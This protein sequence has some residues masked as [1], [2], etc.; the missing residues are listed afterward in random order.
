MLGKTLYSTLPSVYRKDTFADEEIFQRLYSVLGDK[1]GDAYR[2]VA[3][4]LVD[5]S[6]DSAELYRVIK[7]Q[8]IPVTDL[9]FHTHSMEVA[10]GEFS[11]TTIVALPGY[12]TYGSELVTRSLTTDLGL[13]SPYYFSIVDEPEDVSALQARVGDLE[14]LS[15]SDRFLILH[16]FPIDSLEL[17]G[18]QAYK[19]DSGFVTR[20]SGFT[21]PLEDSFLNPGS[22]LVAGA[23]IQV[24]TEGITYEC[25]LASDA[26]ISLGSALLSVEYSSSSIVSSELSTILLGTELV[27][28]HAEPIIGTGAVEERWL[29]LRNCRVDRLDL[30]YRFGEPFGEPIASSENYRGVL[31]ALWEL[32]TSGP[33]F[34][35][36]SKVI[37]ILYGVPTLLDPPDFD[38]IQYIDYEQRIVKT[39]L[40]THRLD[41]IFP[42]SEA[43]A[44][45]A[46]SHRSGY[47]EVVGDIV[48]LE[49]TATEDLRF[50]LSD[51]GLSSEVRPSSGLSIRDAQ[52]LSSSVLCR[53]ERGFILS[54][55]LASEDISGGLQLVSSENGVLYTID[56]EDYSISTAGSKTYTVPQPIQ[57]VASVRD[58]ISHPNWWK[59]SIAIPY[60]LFRDTERRRTVR[61]RVWDLDIGRMPE[62][63]VGDYGLIV[64]LAEQH[65]VAYLLMRDFLAV[66]SLLVTLD[67]TSTALGR[68][69]S[70]VETLKPLLKTA[71]TA[72]MSAVATTFYN[73]FKEPTEGLEIYIVPPGEEAR[74]V[75]VNLVHG[76]EGVN[77]ILDP[78]AGGYNVVGSTLNPPG[79][80][81]GDHPRFVLDDSDLGQIT[82]TID[83]VH[84]I[85]VSIT[86]ID[87]E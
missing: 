64:G 33:V 41:P 78:R 42:I 51:M 82:S 86:I 71:T 47:S 1:L 75:V 77:S 23:R 48:S 22:K 19:P 58:N 74:R 85:P 29:W 70:T 6:L 54:K 11:T 12:I 80:V 21:A 16:E 50:L 31:K 40:R 39:G 35:K 14:L 4:T 67:G 83:L 30:Y 7:C 9:D 38:P 27:S 25:F 28:N 76:D 45:S 66:K 26:V 17:D 69:R 65:E 84:D 8:G 13:E 18:T 24:V 2:S 5:G 63:R 36:V 81:G 57:Q 49:L 73:F 37:S 60:D 62:H 56:A 72:L 79:L 32:S 3:Q 34:S 59:S 61:P 87:N 68:V 55:P 44:L 20:V 53:S 52:G 10:P 15:R 46:S 43:V